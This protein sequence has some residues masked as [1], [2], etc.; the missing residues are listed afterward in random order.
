[1]EFLQSASERLITMY[2]WQKILMFLFPGL[3]H[4]KHCGSFVFG[5]LHDLS[6]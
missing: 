5:R 3:R 2:D 4:P 6:E 1:M